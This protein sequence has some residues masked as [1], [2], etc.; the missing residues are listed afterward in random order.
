MAIKIEALEQSIGPS[1]GFPGGP[2]KAVAAI[3]LADKSEYASNPLL[4]RRC[5]GTGFL[6]RGYD[7][8]FLTA[9]H[10]VEE[11]LGEN[12]T[13]VLAL[14]GESERIITLPVESVTLSPSTDIAYGTLHS[15]ENIQLPGFQIV[16]KIKISSDYATFEH[17][18]TGSKHDG[19]GILFNVRLRKGYIVS[20]DKYEHG[21]DLLGSDVLE[22]SYPCLRGASGSPVFDQHSLELAGLLVQNV[23]H[24]LAPT[25]L[26]RAV[27]DNGELIEEIK[28]T[29]PQGIAISAVTL[30]Q[31]LDIHVLH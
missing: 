14:D 10:V 23:D 25:Q 22:M 6:V 4:V 18:G 5:L 20:H 26:I 28:Y 3:F 13:F 12:E 19:S 2:Y 17:S 15:D 24:E 1:S 30:N 29:I 9:K 21:G 7:F 16:R 31:E 8:H 27:D 11:P